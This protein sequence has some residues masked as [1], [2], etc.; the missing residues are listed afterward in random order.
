MEI[1]FDIEEF[2]TPDRAIITL[3]D[4]VAVVEFYDGQPY[5]GLI[6]HKHT[7][8]ELKEPWLIAIAAKVANEK[9][10]DEAAELIREYAGGFD[11]DFA[12]ELRR[13]DLR[14]AAE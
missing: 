4:L 14:D 12:Y 9:I 11:A 6:T 8:L 2:E 5:A 10:D 13:D 1:N 7:G 3:Y